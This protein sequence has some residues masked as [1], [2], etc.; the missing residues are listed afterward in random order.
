LKAPNDWNNWE[1]FSTENWS[2][3]GRGSYWIA[4]VS[5]RWIKWSFPTS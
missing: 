2:Y 3:A 1:E 4:M 5:W